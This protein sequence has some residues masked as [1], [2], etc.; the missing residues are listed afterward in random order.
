[1]RN[2]S[3]RNFLKSIGTVG[4][5]L[6]GANL[7]VWAINTTANAASSSLSYKLLKADKNGVMLMEGFTSRIV[8]Q[9]GKSV[10]GYKW[11]K[12]AD[13]GAVFKT[14]DGGWIYV[15][16][17]ERKKGGVGAIRFD[18]NAVV[19][20]DN[21]LE[22]LGTRIFGPVTRELRDLTFMKIISLAPEVL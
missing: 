18:S 2:N 1:M 19:L 10:K 4:V 5:Y 11:H 17:S 15:S 21:K 7:P 9:A 8:A 22:P 12:S 3:K 13:G 20:L 14:E 16:N 6:A